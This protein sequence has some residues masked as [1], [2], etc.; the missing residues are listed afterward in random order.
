M[1]HIILII[2]NT[3]SFE[4][5]L[6]KSAR[7]MYLMLHEKHRLTSIYDLYLKF[8]QVMSVTA[9]NLLCDAAPVRNI[10]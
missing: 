7:K 5:N 9:C 8:S 10:Y 4:N 2:L 1:F 6:E 3:D